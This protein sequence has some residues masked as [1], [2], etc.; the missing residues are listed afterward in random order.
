MDLF[1]MVNIVFAAGYLLFLLWLAKGWFSSKQGDCQP[2]EIKQ[3]LF[4]SILIPFRDEEQN[5]ARIIGDLLQQDYP[6][7]SFELIL[8]DDDSKDESVKIAESVLKDAPVVCRIL[9][10]KGGKKAALAHGLHH[11]HGEYIISLDADV[12][13]GPQLLRCYNHAF[14]ND[15]FKLVAGPVRFGPLNTFFARLQAVEFSSLIVS[16]A[17]AIKLNRP[18]MLNAANMGFE[19]AVALEFETQIY[20][21]K[22]SSGDDQFLME[23]V[24]QKY[25]GRAIGFIKSREAI[26]TTMPAENLVAFFRQRIRWASK[27]GS[28]QSVFSRFIALFIAGFNLILLVDMAFIPMEKYRYFF[29]FLFGTKLLLDFPLIHSGLRFLKQQK[30]I[31]Y[32]IPVQLLYPFYVGLTALLSPLIRIRWK[33]RP[34]K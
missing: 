19:K 1:L 10:S 2:D 9:H 3:A 28:Y 32:Y 27:T 5:I 29:F 7:Q 8:I 24:I 16:A 20:S 12:R 17:A 33:G 11:A 25:G 4:F 26:A 23:A 30:L 18:I 21:G 13:I 14:N 15:H 22:S 34:I 31:R 6:S